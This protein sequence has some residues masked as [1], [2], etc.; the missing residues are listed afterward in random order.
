MIRDAP[1]IGG[2]FAPQLKKGRRG[3]REPN[4]QAFGDVGTG[5]KRKPASDQKMRPASSKKHSGKEGK[6]RKSDEKGG[7]KSGSAGKGVPAP[8]GK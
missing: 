3:T 4:A 1:G 7:K 8:G 2:A 5:S 6:E